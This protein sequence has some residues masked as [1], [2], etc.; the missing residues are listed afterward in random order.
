MSTWYY[1]DAGHQRQGPVDAE[2]LARLRREGRI[3]WNTLVWREGLTQWEPLSSIIN[4]LPVQ[5][6]AS[7]PATTLDAGS[8]RVVDSPYAPPAAP[9]LYESPVHQGGEIVYAG[10]WKRFAAYTI[11]GFITSIAS[12]AIQLPLF[13][14]M[15]MFSGG[16]EQETP[17]GGMVL[18]L[19][20]SYAV[21]ILLPMFYFA[22]F[23]SSGKQATPGKM[24]V[25]I[26]VV[27]ETGARISFARGV[28]RYFAAWI[29]SF[30]LLIG[31]IMAAFTDRKRALHDMIASTL[32]VDQW[33]YT[34]RPDLQS[35]ELGVVTIVILVLSALAF[36]AMIGFVVV[37]IG[38]IASSAGGF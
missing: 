7:A 36:L 33:A 20:V 8:G 34:E 4:E 27:T 10:F 5:D 30:I 23:H 3:Q 16:F 9:L 11:D 21:A 29:S 35:K 28:G 38:A 19:I 17:T 25:G 37:M 6:T 32:V 18:A 13:F 26:K 2:E 24:A 1:A 31:F 14:S 12:Y 15:G 22:W